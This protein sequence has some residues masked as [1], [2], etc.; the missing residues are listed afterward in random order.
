VVRGIESVLGPSIERNFVAP[1]TR[2]AHGAMPTLTQPPDWGLAEAPL[3]RRILCR[4]EWDE[5]TA[6]NSPA[7]GPQSAASA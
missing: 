5:M 3:E 6:E 2:W 4:A 1:A 7:G